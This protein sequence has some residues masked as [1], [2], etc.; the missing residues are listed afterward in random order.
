MIAYL[1][2][3]EYWENRLLIG[4]DERVLRPASQAD[5]QALPLRGWYSLV[6]GRQVLF[7]RWEDE[8]RLRIG[9]EP[10][11][12]LA[13]CTAEWQER[14][15]Q[16]TFVLWRDTLCVLRLNYTL[17]EEYRFRRDIWKHGGFDFTACAEPEHFDILL[18]V[19]NVLSD[20][21]KAE[22][23]FRT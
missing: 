23:I 7:Y 15:D 10:P 12:L 13:G 5:A 17:G 3:Q 14:G 1:Q 20:P 4:P 19:R 11:I 8:L 9:D 6:A 21:R 22:T 16:A 2:C 18:W